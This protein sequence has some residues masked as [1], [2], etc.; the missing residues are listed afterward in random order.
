MDI[1][2]V[3]RR[4]DEA[5]SANRRAERIIVRLAV[6][7]FVLGAAALVIAYWWANPYIAGG[8]IFLQGFLYWPIWL[9]RQLR[10]ENIALQATPI[11]VQSLPPDRAIREIAKLLEFLRK[12][13]A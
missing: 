4:I 1:K 8:T 3:N 13:K 7:I 12:G 11:L 10:R 6:G 9:V 5:L 2:A